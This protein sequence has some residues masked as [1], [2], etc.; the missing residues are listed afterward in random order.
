MTAA[1]GSSRPRSTPWR[2]LVGS[3]WWRLCQLS[4]NES[5][6]RG[7]RLVARSWRR[8]RNGRSPI[9]WQREFT[10][11]VTWWSR[12]SVRT[13]RREG[14]GDGTDVAVGQQVGGIVLRQ[15]TV[16]AEQPADVGVQQPAQL[17]AQMRAVAVRR[18]RVA[19]PIG[20]GVVAAVGGDPADDVTLETHGAGHRERDAH[21]PDGPVAA[22]SETAVEA[23][24]DAETRDRVEDEREHDV[25]GMDETPPQQPAGQAERHERQDDDHRGHCDVQP[26]T[27]ATR[28]RCD[29]RGRGGTEWHTWLLGLDAEGAAG[30]TG[31]T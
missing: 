20:E 30:V 10:L 14:A 31:C 25:G 24:R 28:G 1:E 11:Q 27:A 22:V 23:D 29:R 8:V 17:A 13:Q 3:A 9:R 6:A 7:H 16:V 26:V 2:A 19:G 4:P 5:R 15:R 18:V 12:A 21:G